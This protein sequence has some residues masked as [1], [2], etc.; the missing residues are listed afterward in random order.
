MSSGGTS[1]RRKRRELGILP[2]PT[3]RLRPAAL[4]QVAVLLG[5]AIAGVGCGGPPIPEFDHSALH[6]QRL[7]GEP[8]R[9]DASLFLPGSVAVTS[10]F[11]VIGDGGGD[12]ALRLVPKAGAVRRVVSVGRRGDGPVSSD[13]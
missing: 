6:A 3:R 4:A 12:S 9:L 13:S 5:A 7:L 10:S 2:V 8:V 11:V 1:V